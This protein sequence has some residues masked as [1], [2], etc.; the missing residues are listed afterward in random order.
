MYESNR[1]K[2]IGSAPQAVFLNFALVVFASGGLCADPSDAAIEV[3]SAEEKVGQL[4]FVGSLGKE[5]TPDWRKLIVEWRVGGVVLYKV[6][7]DTPEQTRTLTT[8]LTEL[9][10]DE[11]PPFVAID[12]EGGLVQ[13]LRSGVPQL[14]AAM[15]LGAT[16]SD[17]LARRAGRDLGS[18]LRG[19]G[20]NMN[21]A[22]VLDI[23]GSPLN[24]ALRTRVFS[25]DPK[26]VARLGS[27]FVRGQ[28]EAGVA[29]VGKHFPGM[30]AVS[31]D[32][33]FVLPVLDRDLRSLRKRELI[34]FRKAIE[35]GLPAIMTAH[36]T[37]PRIAEDAKTP[38]T[39]SRRVITDVLRR[40]LGFDGVVIT[41]ELQMVGIR[42]GGDAGPLAVQ[43]FL[44]GADMILVVWDRNDRE[45][46]RNAL[47]EAIA[48]GKI[49]PHRLRESLRRILKLKE[50]LARPVRMS[51]PESDIA[52]EIA[53]R[54]I[55]V[56][57]DN[58]LPLR[59]NKEIALLGPDGPIRKRLPSARWIDSPPRF[60]AEIVEKTLAAIGNAATIV[61][62][63][64]SADDA[65]LTA[66]I[67]KRIPDRPFIV[68]SLGPPAETAVDPPAT[69]VIL[70]YS[71]VPAS[72]EAAAEV[73]MGG[74]KGAG[75][76]P[77]REE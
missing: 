66:A 72:F 30:G 47:L 8:G 48:S 64:A 77:I 71:N 39:L 12:Q 45:A 69:S 49:P 1:M 42:G 56:I 18:A 53:S 40:D 74:R 9:A 21:F 17:D 37:V 5:I 16:R 46:I 36:M 11:I 76:L 44:A 28:S 65:K 25:D 4:L 10:G 63:I 38:A 20:F 26:L 68:V 34:P 7:I 35:A 6:N 52:A 73:L 75:R 3:M 43:A 51:R 2:F 22:P 62:V 13:R 15:A 61:F 19:L 41:D 23:A 32:P 59:D 55:T 31:G 24:P 57:R 70:A 67:R 29:S 14:P 60:D 50:T 27:A 54:S 58:D 33:H